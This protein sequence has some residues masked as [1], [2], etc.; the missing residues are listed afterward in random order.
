VS[1][2]DPVEGLA[3]YERSLRPSRS[4]SLRGART[5]YARRFVEFLAS[6][7][8]EGGDP[9]TDSHAR[10]Y[11]VRDFKS[12]LKTV[13]RAKPASVNLALAAIRALTIGDLLLA[14]LRGRRD[15]R[16]WTKLDDNQH[17]IAAQLIAAG[18]ITEDHGMLA[19]SEQL[20][21]AFD[22]GQLFGLDW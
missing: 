22:P 16:S 4:R 3:G 18:A 20:V 7:P 17:A 2:T 21:Y 12:R 15:E 9:L 1:S 14:V 8:R 11:A 13:R 6:W 19:R 10:D 5:G